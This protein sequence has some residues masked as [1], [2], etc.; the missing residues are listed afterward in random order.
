MAAVKQLLPKQPQEHSEQK[1]EDQTRDERKME[2]EIAT[3]VVNVSRQ[4]SQPTFADA[5]PKQ[6]PQNG[7]AD[8]DNDKKFS[9]VLH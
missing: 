2:G 5:A 7:N 8:S 4:P 1:A 9:E 3:R 6:Q